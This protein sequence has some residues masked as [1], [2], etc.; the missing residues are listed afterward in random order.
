MTFH[1][2]VETS[3]EYKHLIGTP[4]TQLSEKNEKTPLVTHVLV[5]PTINPTKMMAEQ[6]INN[7]SPQKAVLFEGLNKEF[8]VFI[9]YYNSWDNS[10]MFISL[11][12]YLSP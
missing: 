6:I 8:N 2:A 9:I 7:I 1:E 10:N 12:E 11:D 3:L 4:F 5:A